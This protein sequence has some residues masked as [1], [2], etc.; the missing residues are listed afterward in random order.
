VVVLP[1]ITKTD[2]KTTLFSG[3]TTSYLVTISNTTGALLIGAVFKDPA[4]SGI[5]ANSVSCAAA[6]GAICPLI[7]TVGAMQGAGI[8]LP[9]LPDGGSLTFTIDATLT[10]SPGDDLTNT[11]SVTVGSQSN[12]ASD[13][14]TI[15]DTIA[16]LPV[17]QS[18]SSDKGSTV[19][20]T[21]TLYNFGTVADTISLAAFSSMGWTV[22]PSPTTVTIAAGGSATVTLD[23]QVPGGAT[24]GEVDT[25]TITATSGINPGKTATAT[26]VTSV[27]EVLTLT[28]SNT[29]AGG[30]G[31]SV[32]YTHRVQS[33]ASSSKSVSLTPTFT[34]G[35]CSG[36]SSALFE[37]DKTTALTSPVTLAANGGYKDF[38]LKLT[39][40]TTATALDTCTATLTAAYTSGAASSVS[41]TDETTV[42]NLLL[43][44]DP[45]YTVENY[46][47]PTGNYV[48]AKGFGLNSTTA[49]EY[50]WYD[51][52]GTEV[53][54]PRLPSTSGTTFPDTC[55]IPGTGPLGTW[56]VQ[57]WDTTSDVLFTQ[58]EFYVGP[59]HLQAS[60]SGTSPA[61]NTDTVIDLA[62]HDREHNVPVDSSGNLVKGGTTDPEDPLMISVT[63][64]GSATIVSTTLSNA[65]ITGQNV[66]GRLDHCRGNRDHYAGFLS[67]GVV[68][69][70]CA[71]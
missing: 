30:A 6:G 49:Y 36:W 48:Y 37:V 41:V 59:D 47:Y 9:L 52:N 65:V 31:A 1:A 22:T 53:C 32:Y 24:I 42:K 66:T 10:G 68:W 61:I 29:G 45:G 62:L 38:V 46:V 23:V 71:G 50:R 40:P 57:I 16:I 2:N 63:V 26:A 43:Y 35:S 44:N 56:V 4:V 14:N 15:V 55:L 69:L 67:R 19:S 8:I 7:S 12:S 20:Y 3:D 17:T 25:T 18:K 39:I 51:A 13:T 70:T 27:T 11:A 64:D 60:Y 33:N 54:T 28:P 21:Y 58:R 5:T 34:A